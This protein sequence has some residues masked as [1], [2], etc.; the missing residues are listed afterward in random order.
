M[1]VILL[2][3][4]CSAEVDLWKTFRRVVQGRLVNGFSRN[5][6]ILCY[7]HRIEVSVERNVYKL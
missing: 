5:D 4:P 6:G 7:L 1:V 2:G 3:C